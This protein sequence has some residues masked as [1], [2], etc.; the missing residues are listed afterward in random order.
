[1]V[2][3]FFKNVFGS[4]W[5][6]IKNIFNNFGSF[7]SGLWNTIK[8]TFSALGTKIGDAMSG[9]VKAGING[10]LGMI[11]GVVNTFIRMINGA[12]NMI[13]LIPGVNIGKLDE[14]RIPRLAKGGIVTR[15]TIAEIGEDGRE[16]VIPLEKNL[17]WMKNLVAEFMNQLKRFFNYQLDLDTSFNNI[18]ETLIEIR[19]ACR[20][21]ILT[22]DI[23]YV[24]YYDYGF[25]KFKKYEGEQNDKS[26]Y[27]NRDNNGDT[28]IFYSPKPINEIEA[29][30][31]MKK[32]KQDMAEGF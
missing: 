27:N 11:E 10:L 22:D 20:S 1:A 5:E 23:G 24:P 29:A 16:A 28:F 6:A 19:D 18:I 14:L 31:Q 2:V 25:T 8:D 21:I 7:F 15:A 26:K 9:A 30:R 3:S 4:A 17:G 12:I 13:N 32:A